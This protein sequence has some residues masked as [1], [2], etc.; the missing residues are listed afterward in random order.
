MTSACFGVSGLLSTTI[1]RRSGL[2]QPAFRIVFSLLRIPS[3]EESIQIFRIF[4]II[5]KNRRGVC[6]MHDV[7]A[8]F[9][10]ILQN[11]V[12][13]PAQEKNVRTCA[14]GNPN[15]G[16][17]RSAVESRINMNDLRP[18]LARLNH[19]LKSHG[20]VF[21]HRRSHDKDG[22]S[23]A[24]ILLRGGRAAASEGSAQT[25][26]RRA[27]SYTGLIADA[28][29]PQSDREELADQ[30]ILFDVQRGPPKVRDRGCLHQGFAVAGF[31]KSALTAL[32]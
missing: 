16:H 6:V 27:M 12:D 24:E 3:G 21:R 5:A 18:A 11:V 4:E 23:V 30:I 19:P 17:R 15:V 13:Q 29:H 14:Q 1:F 26:H 32:P 10:V 31:L 28:D 20:M 7:L 22:V 25:G 8:E 9:F 2:V